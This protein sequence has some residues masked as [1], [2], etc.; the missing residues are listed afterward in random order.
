MCIF[1]SYHT[2]DF[3]LVRRLVDALKGHRPDLEIYFAPRMN[4]PGAYWL[5]TLAAELEK[6]DAVLFLAGERIGPWQ[7]VEYHEAMRLAKTKGRQERPRIVPVIT[8]K[9]APGLPFFNLL[10]QIFTPDPSAADPLTAILAALDGVQS[11]DAQPFFLR[12]NPYKGLAAFTSADAAYFF[13]RE[14]LS[15]EILTAIADRPSRALALVGSSGVGKSSL[16]QA[17]DRRAQEPA[18]AGRRRLAARPGR[19]PALAAAHRAP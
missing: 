18:L 12:F 4:L 14:R 19:Q 15:A 17:G 7:E 3:E 16:A 13:G 11:P 6:A 9:Q 5:P 2:P 10:H 8:A 1:V